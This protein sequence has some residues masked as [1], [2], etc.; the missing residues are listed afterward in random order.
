[1][2]TLVD[3]NGYSIWESRAIIFYLAEKYGKG[4]LIPNDVE[5]RATLIQRLHFDSSLFST[6]G[7][8]YGPVIMKKQPPNDEKFKK[9]EN[10]LGF[11]DT[12]LAANKY[13]AGDQF[14]IADCSLISIISTFEAVEHNFEKCPNIIRWYKL[15]KDEAPGMEISTE[16]IQVLKEYFGVS[17]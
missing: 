8:Y 1:M 6:F 17:K 15:M 5:K 9:M 12:F 10:T 3:E 11:L 2:P 4:K 7:E 14:T 16:W 13:V